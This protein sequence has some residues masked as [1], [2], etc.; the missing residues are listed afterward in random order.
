[1]LMF[2]DC[3]W[4]LPKVSGTELMSEDRKITVVFSEAGNMTVG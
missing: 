2:F 3:S 4:C 1:M